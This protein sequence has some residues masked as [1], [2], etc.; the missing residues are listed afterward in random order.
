MTLHTSGVLTAGAISA[1]SI[2][3]AGGTIAL[4][5]GTSEILNGSITG[6]SVG[7]GTGAITINDGVS[8]TTSGGGQVYSGA[9]T[10]DQTAAGKLTRW[11]TPAAAT[12]QFTSTVDSAST[13]TGQS[14]TVN[15]SGNEIFGGPS[16]PLSRSIT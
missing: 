15:T 16:A 3:G 1:T 6:N 12:L 11:P 2:S 5:G 14:L 4:T 9:V 8:V 13:S 10:L 7:V